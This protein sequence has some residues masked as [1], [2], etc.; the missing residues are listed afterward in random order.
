MAVFARSPDWWLHNTIVSGPA[1]HDKV[2]GSLA[3]LTKAEE[4]VHSFNA[5]DDALLEQPYNA[6]KSGL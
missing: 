6:V 2:Q 5:E 4:G 1:K 3:T